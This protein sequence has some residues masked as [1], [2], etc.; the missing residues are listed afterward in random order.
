MTFFF[1]IILSIELKEKKRSSVKSN[2]F[3]SVKSHLLT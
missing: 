2:W 3:T 1:L